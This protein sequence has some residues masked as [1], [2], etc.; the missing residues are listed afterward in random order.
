MLIPRELENNAE[1]FGLVDI[2]PMSAGNT[3]VRSKG[4]DYGLE[5]PTSSEDEGGEKKAP[6][7]SGWW[8]KFLFGFL[9]GTPL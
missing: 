2:F 5:E 3:E 1:N 9:L 6:L 8:G 4:I 7:G